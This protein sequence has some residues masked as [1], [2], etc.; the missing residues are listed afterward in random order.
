[1]QERLNAIPNTIRE[2]HWL[3]MNRKSTGKKE[4]G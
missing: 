1:M 4:N 3:K 2:S